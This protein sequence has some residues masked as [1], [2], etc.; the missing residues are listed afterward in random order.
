MRTMTVAEATQAYPAYDF[1]AGQHFVI[2]LYTHADGTK[3][4][5]LMGCGHSAADAESDA[6]REREYVDISEDAARMITYR[7]V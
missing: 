1:I 7:V 4:D 2:A 5:L 3:S 6:R